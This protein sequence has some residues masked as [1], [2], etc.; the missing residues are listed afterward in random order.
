MSGTET[1]AFKREVRSVSINTQCEL[2]F[3]FHCVIC[4]S[5]TYFFY[6][7]S[8]YFSYDVCVCLDT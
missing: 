2:V 1:C 7:H 5:L 4:N 3:I 6:D 8:F